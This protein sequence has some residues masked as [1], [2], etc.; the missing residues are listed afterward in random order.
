MVKYF[1]GNVETFCHLSLTAMAYAPEGSGN[2]EECG[3]GNAEGGNIRH[4]AKGI[5]CGSGNA[6]GGNI[7]QRESKAD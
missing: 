3:S 5:E 6:E 1:L 2:R 4:G 7:R